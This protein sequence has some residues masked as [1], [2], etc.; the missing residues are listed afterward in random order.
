MAKKRMEWQNLFDVFRWSFSGLCVTCVQ[1]QTTRRGQSWVSRLD[2]YGYYMISSLFIINIHKR[3]YYHHISSTWNTSNLVGIIPL[4]LCWP[5]CH[6]FQK[7]KISWHNSPKP[8]GMWNMW[9]DQGLD[10]KWFLNQQILQ[11]WHEHK[12]TFTTTHLVTSLQCP[13][14]S[15]HGLIGRH[16]PAVL[17]CPLWCDRCTLTKEWQVTR[18]FMSETSLVDITT[19]EPMITSKQY[20]LWCQFKSHHTIQVKQTKTAL[21]NPW[22]SSFPWHLSPKKK[23]M[24]FPVMYII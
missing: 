5:Y 18:V 21:R 3:K 17:L 6:P 22:F 13:F 4:P 10:L 20:M 7:T 19:E 12:I 16:C 23:H 8:L 15:F 14:G 11:R 9:K 24:L 1:T 2:Q